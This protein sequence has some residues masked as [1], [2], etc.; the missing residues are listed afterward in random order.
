M[1]TVPMR[2]AS[3][4]LVAV[5]GAAPAAAQRVRSPDGAVSFD[6]AVSRGRLTYSVR[7]R[8][9]LV[10]EPSPLGVTVDG[11]DL[12]HP[13]RLGESHAYRADRTFPWHGA[14]A[15]ARDR[16]RGRRFEVKHAG[17]TP[18]TL[19]V[20]VFDDGVAFSYS[21][22]GTGARTIAGEATEFRL[23]RGSTV[24]YQPAYDKYEAK[25]TS[26]DISGIG[27]GAT[28]GPPL[29][30]ALPGGRTH[31]AITEGA[32][33]DYSGM[34][35][36][37]A[38]AGTFRAVLADAAFSLTGPIVTPWR[39]ILIG[40]LNA[41]VNSVIP[42]S[43]SPPPDPRLFPDGPAT[44]WVK[45]GRSAWSW[46]NAT[47]S[48][49]PANMKAYSASASRLGLEYNIVDDGWK[50]WA[51]PW[52]DMA[53]VVAHARALDP[54]VAIWAWVH[55]EDILDEAARRAF[56]ASCRRAGVVGVKVDFMN[57]ETRARVDFQY[58]TLQDAA[59][60]QLMVNFHGVGK[61]TGEARTFPNELTREAVRGKEGRPT[62]DHA[63]LI[64]FTRG[65]AGATDYTPMDLDGTWLNHGTGAHEVASAICI[66]SPMLVFAEDPATV[67]S[68]PLGSVVRD[69][70]AT[71]DETIVLP[72]SRVGEVASLARR[73]GRD[74][75]VGLMNGSKPREV[76]VDFSF[77]PA[78]QT[79]EA[80]LIRDGADGVQLAHVTKETSLSV[81]LAVDGGFVAALRPSPA[82]ATAPR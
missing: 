53:D 47:R 42:A 55:Y 78:G 8:G 17:G 7:Y 29:L 27:A 70:P 60:S 24:W 41:L 32:L 16:H 36:E 65:L 82:R 45:P 76:S 68:H 28:A 30:L 77:L 79:Y 35:L 6:L 25:Y 74:W 1:V 56:L 72:H 80:R 21:I 12:G 38:A 58:A 26:A 57:A 46:L 9:D 49:T 66:T 51:D 14:H 48:V 15:V 2:V 67:L 61:P 69:I 19:D 81:S 11:A 40:D 50:R 22:P 71:W 63:V 31:A 23:R 34:H 33:R 52:T 73:K 13:V 43:V 3:L 75:F 10:V 37:C 5:A 64:P 44:A 62:A 54:P 20:R 4:L 39:V 18:Y 59:A